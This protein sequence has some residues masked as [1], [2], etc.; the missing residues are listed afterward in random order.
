MAGP[1][2][3]TRSAAP[4]LTA[5]LA[6]LTVAVVGACSS[7]ST[8]GETV[9]TEVVTGPRTAV[10]DAEPEPI[11][12][13]PEPALPA[14]VRGAD[15]VETTITDV[16]RIVAA[17]RSGTLAQTVYALGLGDNLVGR[18]TPSFPA[19]EDVPNV[20][21]GGHGLNTEAI[22]DLN[23]TVVL[24]DTSIGPLA[25][26]EQIRAAGVPVVFVDP[27]R[28]LDTVAADI[29]SVAAALGVP[30]EGRALADRTLAEIDAAKDSIPAEH[31]EPTVAF[32]YLRGSAIKMLGGPGSGAD[33]LITAAGGR[34]AGVLAGLDSEF[35]PITS[36]AM[37]AS[38]PDI[39]LVMT[40]SLESVGGAEGMARLPG[41]AQTPAGKTGT[42]VDMDDSILLSFGPQ[43]GR[44]LAALVEAFY[45]ADES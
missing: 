3:P 27:E 10:V 9:E 26:Q 12:T 13:D 44:V 36:E 1:E 43:S 45:P 19:I 6:V 24:T 17:D 38:S 2:A 8:G 41:V 21:P 37:I 25:V 40:H 14:T 29:E 7:P 30:E 31:P 32:L 20:T 15:G 5:L 39:I 11:T 34:D 18:S 22:L 4:L 28:S 42:I 35:V 16:S 23:P 33:A